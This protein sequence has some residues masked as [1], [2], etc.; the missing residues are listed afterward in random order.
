[1]CRNVQ[2]HYVQIVFCY[3]EIKS[4]KGRNGVLILI[5]KLGNEK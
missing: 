4:E 2:M 3:D 1:M 5:C